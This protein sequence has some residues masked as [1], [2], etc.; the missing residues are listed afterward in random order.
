MDA[1]DALAPFDIFA[2]LIVGMGGVKK[3]K[4]RRRP[5]IRAIKFVFVR[6]YDIQ[7]GGLGR[8]SMKPPASSPYNVASG[9]IPQ[10]SSRISPQRS[11]AVPDLH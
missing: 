3:N 11:Q 7:T 8:E 9:S 10:D 1:P 4:C 5:G 2:R 6:P